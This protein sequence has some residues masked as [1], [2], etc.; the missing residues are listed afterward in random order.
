MS[1]I[2][3]RHYMGDD[4]IEDSDS[5]RNAAEELEG[6]IALRCKPSC[7]KSLAMTKLEE[8]V[9][10]ANKSLALHGSWDGEQ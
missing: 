10:W 7:E 1:E 6:I 4:E 3:K 8:C 5:I 2:F 9:M